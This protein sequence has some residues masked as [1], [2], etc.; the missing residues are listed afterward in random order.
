LWIIYKIISV[1]DIMRCL[2]RHKIFLF[3]FLF[4]VFFLAPVESRE[5]FYLKG[6]VN[7]NRAPREKLQML[8]F[9]GPKRARAIL[10]YRKKKGGFTRT[11]EILDVEGIGKD[12]FTS[13]E[14]RLA[15]SGPTTLQYS[16]FSGSLRPTVLIE[17]F[18]GPVKVLDN[19]KYFYALM[20]KIKKAKKEIRICM[21][22]FKASNHRGNLARKVMEELILAAKRGVSVEVLL[23]QNDRPEDHLNDYNHATAN[24]LRRAGIK[25]N[26]DMKSVITH[27]KMVIIDERTIFIGSHNLTHT[28]LG[29]SNEV[30]LMVES[31]ELA[32]YFLEYMRNIVLD[33][34]SVRLNHQ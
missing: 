15:L 8:P 28:A 6:K 19:G 14:N 12:V 4:L 32:G 18:G 30:S 11:R 20:E 10:A 13:I 29:K 5:L 1:K 34:E 31:K 9:I 23:E 17:A 26:F 33:A 2:H 22:L 24:R 7:I 25:V 3:S 21:Y 16:E 27:A